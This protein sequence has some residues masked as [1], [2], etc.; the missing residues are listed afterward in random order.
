MFLS[1]IS[2][3]TTRPGLSIIVRLNC[4]PFPAF[5]HHKVIWICSWEFL[6][7]RRTLSP[8]LPESVVLIIK[9]SVWGP[10]SWGCSLLSIRNVWDSP[11][12]SPTHRVYS[13]HDLWMHFCSQHFCM[14]ALPKIPKAKATKH[15]EMSSQQCLWNWGT[16]FLITG[17]TGRQDLLCDVWVWCELQ[18]HF[19]QP[20]YQVDCHLV[21]RNGVLKQF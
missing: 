4:L 21:K 13:I 16:R 18:E 11:S 15:Y 7:P 3:T 2:L 17:T 5:T 14:C 10:F 1:F 19:T 12:V 6:L 8:Y 20:K 9:D